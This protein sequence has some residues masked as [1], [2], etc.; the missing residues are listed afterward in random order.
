MAMTKGAA[1]TPEVLTLTQRAVR[2]VITHQ[3]TTLTPADGWTCHGIPCTSPA[4]TL[5]DLAAHMPAD[6]LARA[7]HE[8]GVK[9]RTTA[10]HVQAIQARYPNAP[11]AAK[12]RAVTAGD[13]PLVLSKLE[14]GFLKLLVLHQLPRPVTNRMAGSFRVDCRWPEHRVTVELNSYRFHNSRYAWEQDHRRE[15][16]AYARGDAFR[17]YTWGDVFEHPSAMLTELR[18]LL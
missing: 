3:V 18:N 4:R 2:G 1:P 13:S 15:R 12:L 11:G 8:A 17:R 10:R 14:S 5:V 9:Y 16:E 7:A 6:R